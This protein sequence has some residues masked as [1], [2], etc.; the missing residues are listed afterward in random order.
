[1]QLGPQTTPHR[2]RRP[3]VA[4]GDDRHPQSIRRNVAIQIHQ[5]RVHNVQVPH[6]YHA[7]GNRPITRPPQRLRLSRGPA[8]A[9]FN[10]RE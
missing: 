6:V 4:N 2:D 8:L 5:A 7:T 9:N 10:F 1:M 3:V